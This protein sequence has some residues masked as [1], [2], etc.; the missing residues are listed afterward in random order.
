[1]SGVRDLFFDEFYNELE[2]AID[3]YE[4]NQNDLSGSSYLIKEFRD[5]WCPYSPVEPNF[6]E[7][8]ISVDGGVQISRFAYGGFIAV[9]RACAITH[10]RGKERQLTKNVKIHLQEV[11][12]NRDRSFIP[13]YARMIAEYRAASIAARDV[14]EENFVPIVVMDGSLYLGHFPY[15]TREYL[16][17]P[18]LITELLDTISD[19]SSL[20]RD[21]DFPV[22]GI[23]K[24]S[25]VFYLYMALL[26][27][28]LYKAGQYKL[29]E[30]IDDIY[31]PFDLS[32][33]IEN[34]KDF[35]R[36]ILESFLSQKPMCDTE[37][38]NTYTKTEGYTQ[39]LC[40]TPLLLRSESDRLSFLDRIKRNVSSEIADISCVSINRFL[41]NP[42]IVTTY[43]KPTPVSSPM[44][45]DISSHTLKYNKLNCSGYG[46][47]S[48]NKLDFSNLEG[49]LNHLNYWHCNDVEYNVPLRQADI[50]ARFDR[51]LYTTKYE[52]FIISR[53]ERAGVN[54]KGTRR[55]LREID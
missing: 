30:L 49:I 35:D 32:L 39:P 25:A 42:P 47:N 52:P 22:I 15:A 31:S 46:H 34:Y 40:L 55:S 36:K 14:L 7:V 19:L 28:S 24:D 38:V 8:L 16:H 4:K 20:A 3:G 43:W 6:D 1:M 21:N 2:R 48:F 37:L 13:S 51:K 23:S 5:A 18:M 54:V 17:H 45:V 44:R 53:L 33:K 11:Y 41:D 27:T 12:D 29:K 26:K 50:L 10:T 9:A